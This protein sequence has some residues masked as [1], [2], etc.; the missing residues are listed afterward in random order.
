M[1]KST[2]QSNKDKKMPVK[3]KGKVI[4]LTSSGQGYESQ[5]PTN[6]KWYEFTTEHFSRPEVISLKSMFYWS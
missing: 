6:G 1:A 5:N 4:R 2:N 3:F